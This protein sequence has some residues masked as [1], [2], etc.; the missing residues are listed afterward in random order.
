[1]EREG[2]LNQKRYD[3]AISHPNQKQCAGSCREIFLPHSVTL[4]SKCWCFFPLYYSNKCKKHIP[5]SPE[6]FLMHENISRRIIYSTL[7]FT[8][9][10]NGIWALLYFAFA[11]SL[12]TRE[13]IYQRT[14]SPSSKRY[15][16]FEKVLE[17]IKA[18]RKDPMRKCY[19]QWATSI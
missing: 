15:V 16:L 11:V 2:E 8:R 5:L 13:V 17:R 18:S 9:I 10:A 19:E 1:M 6:G 4:N 3:M 7:I 12:K 14:I